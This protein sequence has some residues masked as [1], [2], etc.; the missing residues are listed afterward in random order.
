M[1]KIVRLQICCHSLET[2]QLIACNSGQCSFDQSAFSLVLRPSHR[3]DF[4]S[5]LYT[6]N[7][8][9]RLLQRRG[10]WAISN[11][12][13][14]MNIYLL[15]KKFSGQSHYGP[16]RFLHHW[17]NIQCSLH[18]KQ[19]SLY[20]YNFLW[21]IIYNFLSVQYPPLIIETKGI[22]TMSPHTPCMFDRLHILLTTL[23][24]L[25]PA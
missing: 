15:A 2:A 5:V 17:V 16:L 7:C 6:Y 4:D 10:C 11:L 24:G 23:H 18:C 25:L 20:L 1:W 3:Q 13:Q 21:Y 9:R 14:I 12:Y 8:I 22:Y 19:G